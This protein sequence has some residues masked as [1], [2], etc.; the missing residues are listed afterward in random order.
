MHACMRPKD[1]GSVRPVVSNTCEKCGA[2]P[3]M[4]GREKGAASRDGGV[5]LGDREGGLNHAPDGDWSPF[6]CPT[7]RGGTWSGNSTAR[8]NLS[9]TDDVTK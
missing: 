8:D 2:T 6:A 5:H 1:G 3:C 4:E 9:A 7:A